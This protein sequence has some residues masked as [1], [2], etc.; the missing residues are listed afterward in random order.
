MV[1]PRC[2]CGYTKFVDRIERRASLQSRWRVVRSTG[3]FGSTPF[4]ANFGGYGLTNWGRFLIRVRTASLHMVCAAC[5]RVRRSSAVGGGTPMGG[6]AVGREA[7][8]LLTDAVSPGCMRGRFE[9]DEGV[10]WEVPATRRYISAPS[11]GG[12]PLEQADVLPEGA[13]TAD[14][15]Y[16][17]TL[18]EQ[19]GPGGYRFLLRDRC[20]TTLEP[21]LHLE[22]GAP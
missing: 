2:T 10:V 14:T 22:V 21:V 17:F 3:G 19:A 18:P 13:V 12:E 16:S 8:V 5:S 20:L 9:S 7:F 11:L 4:G 1:T 15:I 6:W